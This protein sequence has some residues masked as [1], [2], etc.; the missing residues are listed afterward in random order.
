MLEHEE[1]ETAGTILSLE[2][3]LNT[4]VNLIESS[5]NSINIDR[6]KKVFGSGTIEYRGFT[7]EE[8]KAWQKLSTTTTN[9]KG[10]ITKDVDQDIYSE[11]AIVN[12]VLSLDLKDKKLLDKFEVNE[13]FPHG[14][15]RKIFLDGEKIKLFA[16]IA[17]ASGFG[18]DSYMQDN[19]L[20]E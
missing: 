19:F 8:R 16:A 6:F 3:L 4:D 5:R 9:V 2:D 15:V 18:E 13:N 12:C 17:V 14:I 1:Q 11:I 10:V 20:D 7:T